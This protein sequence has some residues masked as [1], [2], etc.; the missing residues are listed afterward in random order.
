MKIIGANDLS[1]YEINNELRNGGKLVIYQFCISILVMTFKRGSDIYL[2]RAGESAFVKGL[3]YTL[4]SLILG[5][6]GLPWG[7][8]YTIGSII[9]NCK[10]GK[11]VTQEIISSC[12]E[13]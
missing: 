9:T 12:C 7:P 8:I 11:D 13:E 1:E 10:G 4:L 3:G 2:I 5:W 6:W